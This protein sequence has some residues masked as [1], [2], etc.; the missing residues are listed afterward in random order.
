M[1]EEISLSCQITFI[2]HTRPSLHA[3]P[4]W[5]LAPRS[6]H[7]SQG[8]TIFHWPVS[9]G[10]LCTRGHDSAS[11]GLQCEDQGSKQ[12]KPKPDGGEKKDSTLRGHASA[13]TLARRQSH[14]WTLHQNAHALKAQPD[15]MQP[16]ARLTT[17]AGGMLGLGVASLEATLP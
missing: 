8:L 17:H 1:P 11:C 9:R 2:W 12:V 15:F 10:M 14:S 3:V 16:T 7:G 13:S 4:S 6:L 5:E